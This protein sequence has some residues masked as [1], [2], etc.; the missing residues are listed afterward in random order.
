MKKEEPRTQ[1]ARFDR[2]S[3]LTAATT[4]LE[5]IIPAER[6][7]SLGL[8]DIPIRELTAAQRLEAVEVAKVYDADGEEITLPDGTIKLD[9]TRY[10]ASIVQMSV[11]D[12]ATCYTPEGVFQEGQGALLLTP[13]DIFTLAEQG[14]EALQPLAQ[15]IMNLS[16]MTKAD[17]FRFSEKADDR[18][19][20]AGKIAIPN[21]EGTEPEGM[22]AG[23]D[24][25]VLGAE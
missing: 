23:D 22:G 17:M 14:K 5:D 25:A 16:W 10:W 2:A 3:F 9:N 12:P 15:R 21:D 18:Q 20:P 8:G 4:L 7:T 13:D 1:T 11:L 19:P 24:G 6:V